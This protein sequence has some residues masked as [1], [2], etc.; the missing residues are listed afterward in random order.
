[1]KQASTRLAYR[2]TGYFSRIITDYLDQADTLRSFYADWPD[3]E[4][5]RAAIK[6]RKAVPVDRRLLV[7]A[8]QKQYEGISITAATQ[9]NIDLLGD[10]TTFTVTTAHQNNIFTG[11]LYFIYKILHAIR[12]ADSLTT[13]YDGYRFVPVYYIGSEDADLAELNHI[14]LDGEKLVWETRQ[15]GAVG[16]MKVDKE[17]LQLVD[18]AE[19]RLA[20]YPSGQEFVR[21]L[22]EAYAAGTDIQQATLHVVNALFGEMGLVVLA[23]DNAVLKAKMTAVFED[24]LFHHTP[25][26]IVRQASAHLQEQGYKDQAYARDIN[27][28]Y[29]NGDMRERIEKT[30]DTF[31]VV[32]TDIHFTAEG[33]K[34]ELKSHPERF[35]PNVI[36]RGLYQCSILPDVAFIGGGGELAYWLQLHRLFEHYHI[37]FPVLVLR[38][39]FLLLEEREALLAEKLHISGSNFFLPENKLLEQMVIAQQG[40]AVLLNGEL[41]HISNLYDGLAKRAGNIDATLVKHVAALKKKSTD[42]LQQLEKKM[43]RAEKRKLADQ[44]RQ[45]QT[46]R[47]KTFPGNNL[48]ERT[49][50]IGYYY[51]KYGASFIQELYRHSAALEQQFTIISLL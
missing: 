9:A 31:S 14:R 19:G 6:K 38:N 12:L 4:G 22:R 50:N 44:R 16:R 17:L 13:L 3:A 28:F 33:L 15:T 29:L 32:N 37:P 11:P 41:A 45:L 49:D 34:Q 21:M 30:G 24:D 7:A 48:Q 26:A 10:E 1:M 2:D 27:L 23:P 20:I 39:S 8:L 42:R 18:R 51:A 35:S 47:A 25:A 43:I 40:E 36:L 5:I 46:L